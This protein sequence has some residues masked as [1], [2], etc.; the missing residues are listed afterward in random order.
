MINGPDVLFLNNHFNFRKKNN[1]SA[2]Y[3]FTASSQHYV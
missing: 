1:I 3:E 2:K